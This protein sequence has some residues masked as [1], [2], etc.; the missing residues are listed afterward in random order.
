MA[1][2]TDATARAEAA[3]TAAILEGNALPTSSFLRREEPERNALPASSFYSQ[4]FGLNRRS[5][6]GLSGLEGAGRDYNGEL[7]LYRRNA[8]GLSLYCTALAFCWV[9][10]GKSVRARWANSICGV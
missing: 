5:Y 1:K 9:N 10:N 2:D 7:V 4:R 6:T 3:S 8:L